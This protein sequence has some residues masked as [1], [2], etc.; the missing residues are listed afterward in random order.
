[1]GSGVAPPQTHRAWNTWTRATALG[2]VPGP[3]PVALSVEISRETDMGNIRPSSGAPSIRA[4]ASYLAGHRKWR[5]FSRLQPGKLARRPERLSMRGPCVQPGRC[6]V[7]AAGRSQRSRECPGAGFPGQ[8]AALDFVSQQI[9]VTRIQGKGCC[10]PC[11][12]DL[13]SLST[14]TTFWPLSRVAS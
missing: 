2:R 6:P 4:A 10:V 8:S 11:K 5:Q 3:R 1:M 14:G 9:K 12:V 7:V 13:I